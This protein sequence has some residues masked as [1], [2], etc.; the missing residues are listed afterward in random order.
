M[1]YN[2]IINQFA[3]L[4]LKTKLD[5]KDLSILDYII[6]ICTSQNK[7]IINKRINGFTW[8]DYE[9]LMQSL[10]LLGIKTKSSITPRIKK[11]EQSGFI[12]IIKKQHQ[13]IF[14]KLTEK[15]DKLR[16][17]K[18]FGYENFTGKKLKVVG[19]DY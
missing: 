12:K 3:V 6:D 7:Y 13:T 18:G 15:V 14:V 9:N 11:I 5:F 19:I 1:K 8:I 10:P 16:Y 17:V 2:I 4:K